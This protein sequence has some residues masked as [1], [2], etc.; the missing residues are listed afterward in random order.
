MLLWKKELKK[1]ITNTYT[2]PI[3][4]KK[5]NINTYYLHFPNLCNKQSVQHD[6][7]IYLI[8][9]N[10]TEFDKNVNLNLFSNS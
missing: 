4:G 10:M 9:L 2:I 6:K 1:G 3:R 8:Y 7:F 5:R